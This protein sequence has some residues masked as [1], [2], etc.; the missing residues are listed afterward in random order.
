[1]PTLYS[2]ITGWGYYAPERVV[3][4]AEL[5]QTLDTSDEW[6]VQR[7]GIRQRHVAAAHESTSTLCVNAA[8]SALQRA[9]LAA[10][11]LDLIIVATS[12]P[13]QFA[14]PVSSLV[15]HELGAVDVPA[16]VLLN[17]CSGF[18]YALATAHQFI[19]SGLYRNI[20]VIG[21]ELLSRFVD[22]TD[23][24]TCVLFGDAAGA[25]VLSASTVPGG[26][27]GI[28]LGSDGSNAIQ[29]TMPAGG[30]AM[31]ASQQTVADGSHYIKMNG[32]EVFKFAS[33]V[34]GRSCRKALEQA[35]MTLDQ[36]DWI[37]PHQANLRIIEAAAKDMNL[38]LERFIVNIDRYAN[39]SAASI[40]IALAEQLDSGKL[41]PGDRLLMVAFGAGLTWGAAVVEL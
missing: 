18:V 41:K 31:P 38:P 36:V 25:L 4:N 40:P 16:F 5:A 8:R 24:S 13:D 33:R 14:P 34:V 11:D 35:E 26:V 23:R 29:I 3:T 21:A 37:I 7:S 28:S 32:R 22:W 19:A 15:Q 2:R 10:T 20:L 6:I 1:M 30:S 12:T 9:N 39:T 17:G 27:R